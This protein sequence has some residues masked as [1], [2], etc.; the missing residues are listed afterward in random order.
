MNSLLRPLIE[1]PFP[2]SADEAHFALGAEGQR[3]AIAIA[4]INSYAD[5]FAND[6]SDLDLLV[7]LS[8]SCEKTRDWYEPRLVSGRRVDVHFLPKSVALAR[9]AK[10]SS[11]ANRE[12][13]KFV[14]KI[15]SAR[16]LS[17]AEQVSEL[18]SLISPA[19]FSENVRVLNTAMGV[20]G[21]ED[22]CGF[23]LE[24]DLVSAALSAK[25]SV[26]FLFD[27]YLACYGE[28]QPKVKWRIKKAVRAL[29]AQHPLLDLYLAVEYS[30]VSDSPEALESWIQEAVDLCRK[31]LGASLFPRY[32]FLL[33]PS[34]KQGLRP[35]PYCFCIRTDGTYLFCTPSPRFV[36]SEV[37]A[38]IFYSAGS[39]TSVEEIAHEVG[40]YLGRAVSRTDVSE[41]LSLLERKGLLTS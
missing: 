38:L 19:D 36:G 17:G 33:R 9:L 23:V 3:N 10:F 31:L 4:V 25:Q 27:A 28:T 22:I 8:E 32:S 6:R 30:C 18:K 5:G 39:T 16:P 37:G 11:S 20:S 7:L 13:A 1:R 35:A 24:R 21:I 41:A 40:T 14:H 26:A 2:L 12:D 15:L 34:H 29:G